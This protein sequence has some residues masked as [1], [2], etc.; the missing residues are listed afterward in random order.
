MA[1]LI[2]ASGA[3]ALLV[4]LLA[5]CAASAAR[6]EPGAAR[7]LWDDGRKVGGRTEVR[8]VEDDKEVQE[9]GRY[10][11]EEHNRRREEGCEG[12]GVCGR[13]EFAR[14]VSAQRQVVSGIKYYLRVAAAEENGAGSNVVSDGR[15]FDAVVVVKPWLQSR[16]L[17]RFAPADA[18]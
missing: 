13:L 10:S 12:G 4:V 14:V 9:L 17:V 1:R 7:Q 5:A 8:D 3:C 11:V 15:V 18:K 2:G 6:T 16:A